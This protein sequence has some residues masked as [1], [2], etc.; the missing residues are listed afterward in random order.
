MSDQNRI[1]ILHPSENTVKD[2]FIAE[3]EDNDNFELLSVNVVDKII[4]KLKSFKD[5]HHFVNLMIT[6]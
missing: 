5:T 2:Y 3:L 6:I 4:H 1:L